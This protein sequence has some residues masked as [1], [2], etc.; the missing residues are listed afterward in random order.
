M[1]AHDQA[2]KPEA[3]HRI[4]WPPSPWGM[5]IAVLDWMTFP[6][7]CVLNMTI[8]T[9]FLVLSSVSAQSGSNEFGQ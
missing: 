6:A 1:T 9:G 8:G 2:V 4:D 3:R 7:A 5:W